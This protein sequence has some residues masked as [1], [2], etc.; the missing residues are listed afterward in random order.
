[1]TGSVTKVVLNIASPSNGFVAGPGSPF[2]VTASGQIFT[3]DFNGD[4]K[5][6]LAVLDYSTGAVAVLLGNGSG[7]FMNAAGL[8][9]Q[10]GDLYAMTIGDFNN[11]GKPDVALLG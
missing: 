5:P 11:D 3:A 7:G 8:P 10:R 1:Y 4:G 6:D 2:K 9:A